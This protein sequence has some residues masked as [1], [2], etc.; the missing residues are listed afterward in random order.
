MAIEIALPKG[1]L[2]R[3]PPGFDSATLERVRSGI[4]TGRVRPQRVTTNPPRSRHH[5]GT[6][7]VPVAKAPKPE[8]SSTVTVDLTLH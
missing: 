6:R 1:R 5:V 3:V 7:A 4:R 8:L 2:L